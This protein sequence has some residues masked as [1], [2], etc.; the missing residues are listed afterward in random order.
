M[1]D[2][3]A[4]LRA[5]REV[6]ADTRSTEYFR[7]AEEMYL[8]ARQDY[9]LKNFLKAREAAEKSREAA[10]RA[11]FLSIRSG[12]VRSSLADAPPAAEPTPEPTPT[13]TTP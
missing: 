9:R 13:P 3:A 10:E 1:S 12:A 11:E 5:A 6:Q 8:K 4:A 7:Y 2:A